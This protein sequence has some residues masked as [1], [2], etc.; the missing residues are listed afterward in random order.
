[1]RMFASSTT[2]LLV[3]PSVAFAHP[4][5]LRTQMTLAEPVYFAEAVEMD[6]FMRKV[7]DRELL[8]AD[9]TLK[10]ARLFV[11]AGFEQS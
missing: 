7:A 3:S 8:S 1:M 2:S 4:S 5:N 10:G 9:R 6:Y 11:E